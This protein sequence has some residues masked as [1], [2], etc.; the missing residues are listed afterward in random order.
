MSGWSRR[1]LSFQAEIADLRKNV[2]GLLD[3]AERADAEEDERFGSDSRGDELP[4]ELRR[5][6]T[7]LQRIKEAKEALERE[8]REA[9]TARPAELEAQGK[10]PRAPRDGRDPFA[11]K[12]A[13]QRNFT[14]PESKI[15][16]TSDGSY[17]QCYSG[18]AIVD[19]VSQV[20][21]SAELSDQA[22][23]QCQLELAV[24]QLTEN[25]QT[26]GAQLP[27]GAV[28]TADGGYFSE[29]NVKTCEQHGV[30]PYIAT[31]RFKH[32]EPPPAAVGAAVCTGPTADV[33][34]PGGARADPCCP[35]H[36]KRGS[37][38]S[39]STAVSVQRSPP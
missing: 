25:L 3:E 1:R 26:I 8:A 16:K 31:G 14:D 39:L 6:E 7:R 13:A 37:S 29:E 15:M 12:P 10:K 18:Q 33:G 24:E 2:K 19:S 28:L 30:D 32:D 9:E 20:I 38:I 4:E 21:V 35:N 34:K 36:S 23:D 27:K 11:P 17:H 5:R 22:A